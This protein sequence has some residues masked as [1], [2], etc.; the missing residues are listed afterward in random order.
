MIRLSADERAYLIALLSAQDASV[1]GRILRKLEEPVRDN[2]DVA[3][4]FENVQDFGQKPDLSP[5]KKLF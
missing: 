4:M 2:P 3:D 1:A 5:F